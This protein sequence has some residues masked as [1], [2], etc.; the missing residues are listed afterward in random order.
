MWNQVECLP[1]RGIRKRRL[2]PERQVRDVSCQRRHLQRS[3]YITL[4]DD[5]RNELQAEIRRNSA[6]GPHR[7]QGTGQ[8]DR[9][10]NG[11]CT[12]TYMNLGGRETVRRNVSR[13]SRPSAEFQLSGVMPWLSTTAPRR[14]PEGFCRMIIPGRF[15]YWTGY[16][17]LPS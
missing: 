16:V 13:V 8:L 4:C 2:E 1:S 15:G 9:P 7:A 14:G 12:F 6:R 3:L 5:G 17:P 10:R 11:M